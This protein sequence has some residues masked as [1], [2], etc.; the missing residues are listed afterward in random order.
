MLV[1]ITNEPRD[2]A[3][4]S[5]TLLAALEGR[6]PAT[7]PEAE[8][9]FGDHPAD[10][11]D[12]S[13]GGTLDAL[14]G[15]SLSYLLKLLAAASPLSIQVHPTRE[16]ARVGFAREAGLDAADPSR[17]YRDP[18]HKPE[19]IVALSE[20]FEALAGLR[21]VA[22]TQQVLAA[23]P[24]TGA[25]RA[26]RERLSETGDDEAGALRETI[27]WL[28]SASAE[29]EVAEIIEAVAA[30]QSEEHADVLHAV[31]SIADRYP[32]DPGVVVALLMNFMVL[33]EGEA[34]FLRAGLLHAYV[35][36]LGVEI[37]AASDN[38]LR[39]GLTAKHIDPDELLAIADTTPG[40]VPVQRHASTDTRYDVPVDDFAL[41]RLRVDGEIGVGLD[42][43]TIL[44][45][46]RGEVEVVGAGGTALPVPVGT[47]VFASADERSL[48]VQGRGEVF[49]AEP[50]HAS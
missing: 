3:W 24:D 4:G 2:Y 5:R 15:G 50:G 49:I 37:M 32:G 11:A 20:R 31:R 41:R 19:L 33:R 21:P 27:A 44:L 18:N 17:N 48:T 38:V 12:V 13:G 6:P 34:I 23:L 45:A 42:G 43:P 36:G 8:V 39:G 1:S 22:E 14:T 40:V 29:A 47:A 16:Q 7:G 26:L 9:W 35:S 28:L 25:V 46:T 30:A 10:P